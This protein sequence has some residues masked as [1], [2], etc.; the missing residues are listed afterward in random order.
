MAKD[1][2]MTQTI[3]TKST[4]VPYKSYWATMFAAGWMFNNNWTCAGNSTELYKLIRETDITLES[5]SRKEQ[6]ADKAAYRSAHP[7]KAQSEVDEACPD[8]NYYWKW[9]PRNQHATL[10]NKRQKVFLAEFIPLAKK[11]QVIEQPSTTSAL[12]AYDSEEWEDEDFD[13]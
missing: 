11:A 3:H 12:A 1:I 8:S 2:L 7:T 10:R 9:I 6:E 5:A 13:A 4:L